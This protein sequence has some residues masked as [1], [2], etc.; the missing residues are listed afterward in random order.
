MPGIPPSVEQD[1][2]GRRGAKLLERLLAVDG[3][4]DLVFVGRQGVAQEAPHGFVVVDDHDSRRAHWAAP[5]ARFASIRPRA[6][7]SFSK[8]ISRKSSSAFESR[9]EA[10]RMRFA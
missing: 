5:R 3:L 4:G 10:S 7:C 2:S 9:F 6:S 1:Q 8:M